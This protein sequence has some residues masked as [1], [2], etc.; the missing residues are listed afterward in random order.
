MKATIMSEWYQITADEIVSDLQT[1][2]AQGLSSSQIAERQA[3]YGPNE[4]IERA[5]KSP[6]SIFWEQFTSVLVLVLIAAA[7][8]SL[9]L[10]DYE[11]AVVILLIV[12]LN[13]VLGFR[14]EYNAE[15]AMAALK[16]LAVPIVRVRREGRVDEVSA[17]E[18]V[19]GDVVMLEAGN[20]VPAD[21]RLLVSVN[22]QIEEASLTGESVPVEKDA[23]LVYSG[24]TA[25]GDRRNM[26][27][28][29][30]TVTYGRGEGVVTNT[31]MATELGHI[32]DLLQTVEHEAT[33][34]QKKL[35]RLGKVLALVALVLVMVVFSIGYFFQDQPFRLMLLTAVSLAVAAVPEGL[36][37]VVTIALSIGAQRMLARKAL[38][39][40]LPAVETLGS[41]TII[42]SDKTGTL[43]E[44]QMTVTVLDVAGRR[45]DLPRAGALRADDVSDGSHDADVDIS[46][47]ALV[48][49]G[50]ALCNDSIITTKEDAP[51]SYKIVGDPTE[52]ALAVVA[53]RAGM[54]KSELELAMPRVA[55]IPFDSERKRMTTIHASSEGD[56]AYPTGL[57]L[58]ESA[59][60]AGNLPEMIAF[61]K[62]ASDSLLPVSSQVLV[63][64]KTEA[65]TDEIYER[66]ASANNELAGNGM[67]VLGVAYKPL[68]E[69]PEDMDTVEEDLTFVGL[70]GMI[71]PPRPE[72]K[73][74]VATSNSAGIRAMMI[75][76]DHPLTARHIAAELGISADAG[77]MIGQ[78]LDKLDDAELDEVVQDISVYARVS[79]E[80]KLQI[81][82]SLQRQGEIVAMTGDGV[83]DAPALKRADIGVA[84]GITGTDVAKEAAEM[85][86]QDDNFAT[87]VAA[88]EEGRTIYDNIRKF[89]R[90]LLTCNSGEIWVMLLAPF[91][92]MPLPLLPLQ[93]LWMNLVTDGFPALA[94]GVEP[95]E[96]DIMKRK[97]HP[98][99]EGVFARGMGADIIWMGLLMGIAPL[100][101]GLYYYRLEDPAWQTMVF[102]A[103]VM[104]QMALAL[105]VRSERESVF[106]IGFFSNPAILGAIGL[107]IVLQLLVI[108][109]P[110]LQEFFDTEP[111][112][113]EHLIIALAL[114][115]LPFFGFEL[116][117]WIVRLMG[118]QSEV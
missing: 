12:V 28:M 6:W 4:L 24:N 5:G 63:D 89:I 17:T 34:L 105:A 82:Q 98:P 10:G 102:T 104:S 111:L 48:L 53:A 56:G 109:L 45:L 14:Q 91:L 75:T 46:T 115:A 112:D 86:L 73:D 92:G 22:L 84:M 51:Y 3:Q 47:A 106:K 114:S 65:M 7:I 44:N 16:Q 62:G 1:D 97:P 83:N 40:K 41:V 110:F 99:S 77:L 81:V 15:K 87:I 74:A 50:G 59:Y 8:V 49:A 42:C 31:G 67:R 85:V 93:I 96:P 68:S 103:L 43:T 35:D 66:I 64:G 37:A 116:K 94:L 20:L 90:F 52:G 117:K 36:P 30:T 80:H 29:G 21:L 32:A 118:K 13:A 55:E 107:T 69:M 27:Y 72:A 57:E 61:T 60:A 58:L 9:I 2:A 88:I 18:I 11:D 38:I 26:A 39:R 71:D 79:P 25:L 54:D 76:G 23:E 19:P 113:A 100:A 33:P 70:V 78:D 101:M 95:A 108:Y